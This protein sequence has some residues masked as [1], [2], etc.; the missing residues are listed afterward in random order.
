M[1]TTIE[2]LNYYRA[3]TAGT[4][5]VNPID[6]NGNILTNITID[7][8][9][10]LGDVT[11]ELPNISVFGGR[12]ECIITVNR[13]DNS[14]NGVRVVT[15]SVTPGNLIGSLTEIGLPTRY[16]SVICQPVSANG[17]AAS[18]SLSNLPQVVAGLNQ[19]TLG[20]PQYADA[21][22]GTTLCVIDYD[23]TG[24]GCTIVKISTVSGDYVDWIITATDDAVSTNG[25]GNNPN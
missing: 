25:I 24:F 3:V 12:Y 19:S 10:T 6:F 17:W 14:L 21:V 15:D 1:P 9:A 16:D 22:L 7:C 8:D 13:L 23:S 20:L 2:N 5:F 18:T 11:I 4:F